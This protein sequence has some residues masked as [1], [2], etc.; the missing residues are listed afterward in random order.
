MTGALLAA[1]ALGP[2]GAQPVPRGF[3]ASPDV[4]KVIAENPKYRV[5]AVTWKPGQKDQ[6]HGHPDSAVYYLTD[7]QLRLTRPD[8][9]VYEGRPR[10]GMALL[11]EPVVSHV[12][13]NVGPADCRI[14]MFELR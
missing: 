8:G 7:C 12:V 2:A 9:S 3:E 4:Y 5:V 11:Q 6:P 1:L 14:V 13:E 10:A